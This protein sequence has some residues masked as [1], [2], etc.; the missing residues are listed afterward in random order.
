[1][2]QNL[3]LALIQQ[4]CWTDLTES[5]WLT[6]LSRLCIQSL[7]DPFKIR[8]TISMYLFNYSSMKLF[9]WRCRYQ[10]SSSWYHALKMA[11]R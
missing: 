11:K 4:D 1:M 8:Y 3:I 9:E 5:S 6:K 10:Q 2:N 7:N